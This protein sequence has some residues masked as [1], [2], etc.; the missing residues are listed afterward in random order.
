MV[1]VGDSVFVDP[2]E[3]EGIVA[4]ETGQEVLDIAYIDVNGDFCSAENGELK[5]AISKGKS[6]VWVKAKHCE[7]VTTTSE[8]F[9]DQDARSPQ[10]EELGYSMIAWKDGLEDRPDNTNLPPVVT[11]LMA[12]QYDKEGHYG[13]SWKGKGEYRGIMS[14]IDRKYDRL[15]HL[16]QLE[17]EKAMKSLQDLENDL[18][19]KEI[20]PSDV[21]ESKIDAIADLA[22]YCLLYMTYVKEQYPRVFNVW[23]KKNVPSYLAEKIPF[24]QE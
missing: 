2:N 12:I 18:K 9:F 7:P 15:D 13:S 24:I 20:E 11:M 19:M 14:N 21:P 17:I 3:Y 8:S 5:Y 16:T 6:W 23:V 10:L 4:D 1:N 22:N